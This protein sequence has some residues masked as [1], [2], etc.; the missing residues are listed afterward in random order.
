[1]TH[2]YNPQA[3]KKA[4]NLSVN[5]DL[6]TQAKQFNIN[7]SATL[8]KALS[9]EVRK[10][11]EKTWLEENKEALALANQFVEKHGLFSDKYRM[12]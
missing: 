2:L 6:L 1:M 10:S 12:F 8:E 5:S 3:P 9:E 11:K 4:A 7:L